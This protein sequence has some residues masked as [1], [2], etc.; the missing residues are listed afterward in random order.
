MTSTLPQA[1]TQ[2][3]DKER[4]YQ[5]LMKWF[6]TTGTIS[7]DR[8]L[9]AAFASARKAGMVE[10]AKRR[11]ERQARAAAWCAAAFGV[12][13][14]SSVPQRG[15]RML[16]EAIEAYQACGCPED[17]AHKLVSYVFSRPIGDLSQELG[18][19]G[20]TV[21]ALAA[22]AKLSAD[23]AEQKELDRVL[24]KPLEWFAARN[25]VKNDAGFEEKAYPAAIRSAAKAPL[26]TEEGNG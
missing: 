15:L 6:G 23:D 18:G 3:T 19:I 11:D 21:L 1:Q 8:D 13:H 25:K 4:A 22:A 9:E 20:L 14:Q 24:A 12:A 17:Q 7:V 2:M 16:E 26:K 10:A 5:F